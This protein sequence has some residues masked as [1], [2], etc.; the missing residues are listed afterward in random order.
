MARKMKKNLRASKK[1]VINKK[2]Y[3]MILLCLLL[4]TSI[5]VLFIRLIVGKSV[6]VDNKNITE[7]YN[8]ISN[9]S[10]DKCN[11][12]IMYGDS[13]ITYNDLSGNDRL[14]ITYSKINI[15]EKDYENVVLKKD[16][17]DKVCTLEGSKVFATDDY[18]GKKCTVKKYNKDLINNQYKKIFGKDVEESTDIFNVDDYNVCYL[19][20]DSYY[21]GLSET[22][23]FTIGNEALI[24]RVLNKAIE[25]GNTIIIYDYFLKINDSKCYTSYIG[26][27]EN[28][29]CTK[30]YKS[31]DKMSYKFLNKYGTKYK[32]I[33]KK[34]K[35]NDYYS[36]I[37][38]V[39]MK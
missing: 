1:S 22:F 10:L 36:W 21:C 38:S 34:E 29:D 39:P 33:F 26:T 7:L 20:N 32:H 30:N 31:K 23:S 27:K 11:G 18:E 19:Y 25:K 8:Y 37:S 16:K 15:T 17:K 3:I 13:L 35:E 5:V 14:C 2:N 4:F 28:N 9:E 6:N 12:L 24:Y